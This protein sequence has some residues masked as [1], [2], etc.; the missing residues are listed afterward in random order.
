M[1]CFIHASNHVIDYW[2]YPNPQILSLRVHYR[3]IRIS[4]YSNNVSSLQGTTLLVLAT[5]EQRDVLSS[6]G[7]CIKIE[8][9]LANRRSLVPSEPLDM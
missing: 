8:S 7:K 3:A 5:M 4:H 6:V 1:F 9:H 2:I